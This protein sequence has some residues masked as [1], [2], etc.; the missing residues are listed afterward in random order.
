MSWILVFQSTV[1]FSTKHLLALFASGP[2]DWLVLC[3]VALSNQVCLCTLIQME[4]L[5][6]LDTHNIHHG[7]KETVILGLTKGR[8][9]ERSAGWLQS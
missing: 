2:E 7:V 8:L 9:P 4:T 3:E 5:L 6:H 1:S